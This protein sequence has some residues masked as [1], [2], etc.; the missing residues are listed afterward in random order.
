MMDESECRAAILRE[1]QRIAPEVEAASLDPHQAL[2]E[3][4]DL[5]SMDW[6]NFLIALSQAFRVEIPESVYERMRTVDD[7]VEYLRS[8]MSVPG[9]PR[10]A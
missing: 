5:D 1:L 7:L 8:P 10:G 9:E 2:R 3:Q 6:L 4:V